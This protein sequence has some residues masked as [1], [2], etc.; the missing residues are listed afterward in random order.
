[1]STIDVRN[2]R[3]LS[4][5]MDFY[6]LTM[7]NG[8]FQK[9]LKDSI[10]YFDMFYR[11]NPDGGGFAIAAGLEQIV[12]YIKNLRFTKE[13]IDFLRSKNIFSEEFLNY[14]LNFK[15]SGSIYAI[16]EGT[17]VFPNEPIL[18]VKAKA[19]EA[20]LLETMILVSINHQSLIA[21]KA[22]RIVRAAKG[23]DVLEFGARRSQGYDGAIYGARAAYIGGVV[24][25]ATTIAD[26]IFGVPAIGTMAHSWIQLFGDEFLAF[27]T[28]ART[29]PDSCVLLVDTYNIL[30]SGVPNAIRVAKE[31]LEP[32]GKRLKGIRLDSGDMSYLSKKCRQMLD[33]AGLNDCKITVSNSLD[34]YIITDLLNQ[35][36]EIDSFGVGERLVTAKSEPVF[37]GVYK[38][39]AIEENGNVVPRIKISE[40]PEKVTNP[41]FKQVWRLYDKSTNVAIADVITLYD[42]E[43]DDTKPY[44]IFDPVHTWKKKKV[45]DFV[46]KKLQVPVF[47]DGE[48]VY[49]LP[50]LDDIRDYCSQQLDTLW[51]EIKR[52]SFPHQYYVDLSKNLWDC[53][54]ELIEKYSMK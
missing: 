13:N 9:G 48:C 25:T 19:I 6:E 42:E 3:N 51:N 14:L 22:N 7:S 23:R 5:L 29:Y 47:I 21:T 43:I 44:T 1:M 46:A 26:E 34:E 53:K 18:T 2:E 39:V 15:F 16:P 20:Q 45:T 37:G 40:N 27:E 8:Y 32:M 24:G 54:N 17:P 30:K 49:E 4:M 10:V 12:D 33:S 52:F 28:Y 35:G 50:K 31:V 11:K 38:L 36:A 41:G